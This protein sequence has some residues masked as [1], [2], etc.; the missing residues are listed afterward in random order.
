MNHDLRDPNNFAANAKKLAARATPTKTSTA[1]SPSGD[2][3]SR[4]TY[5]GREL[6][7]FEGRAGAMRAYTL[8]SRGI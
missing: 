1:T 8:P 7:P 5:D 3:F 2:L 4:S 6:R